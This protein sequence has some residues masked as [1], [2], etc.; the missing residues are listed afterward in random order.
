MNRSEERADGVPG[1][2]RRVNHR[3]SA[4]AKSDE[5]RGTS[6]AMALSKDEPDL[7]AMLVD[8]G[9]DPTGYHAGA[10][11]YARAWARLVEVIEAVAAEDVRRARER[12]YLFGAP[13]DPP[14]EDDSSGCLPLPR[15][16]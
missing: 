10:E 6:L 11:Q 1:L 4:H 12:Q 2:R 14:L 3:H 9:L 15:A 7:F 13:L 5:P 8:E 16:Q